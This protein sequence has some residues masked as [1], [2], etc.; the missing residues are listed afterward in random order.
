M[1]VGG[2]E[3]R[4]EGGGLGAGWKLLG[5]STGTEGGARCS[6]GPSREL[7]TLLSGVHRQEGRSEK[8]TLWFKRG[9]EVEKALGSKQI[10]EVF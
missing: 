3:S 7:T 6:C 9:E 8:G 5:P 4:K 1:E 2:V 10:W